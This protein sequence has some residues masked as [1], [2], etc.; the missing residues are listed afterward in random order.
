MPP[1][2]PEPIVRGSG[3]PLIRAT[4]AERDRAADTATI[5]RARSTARLP[6]TTSMAP[7]TAPRPDT[8]PHARPDRRA[9]GTRAESSTGHGVPDASRVRRGGRQRSLAR[10]RPRLRLAGWP[11]TI[12]LDDPPL[13]RRPVAG[14]FASPSDHGRR[15]FQ[16][17]RRRRP[18]RRDGRLHGR[19]PGRPARPARR[20]RRRGQ[21]RRDL[22]PPGLHPDQGAP[23]IGRGDEPRPAP[24][25]LRGRV[26]G[27]A[28]RRL[29]PDGRPPRP[30]REAHVDGAQDAR[31]Q[32]Q[33]RLGPGSRQARGPGSASGSPRSRRRCA[34]GLGRRGAP[35]PGD[36][37]HPG[38]RFAGEEPARP[39]PRREADPDERRCPAPGGCPEEHRDRGRR[40]RRRRVRQLLPRH[41]HQG[42]PPRV[43]AHARA[44]SRTGT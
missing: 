22:P 12:A 8:G 42:D 5:T 19:L 13:R 38:D 10:A 28:G 39:D 40:S 20:P 2:R 3:P 15:L 14:R 4:D 11:R 29:R 33:G 43:P 16:R 21:D 6:G 26:H 1:V 37:H 25:G 7:S 30:G 27:R 44:R 31:R 17:L 18:G 34:R 35:P 24:Q 36:R 9:R 32:E 23:R 41:R